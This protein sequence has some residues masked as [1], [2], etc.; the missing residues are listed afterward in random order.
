MK[1]SIRGEKLEVTKAI[2]DYAVEKLSKLDKYL[3][4][5]DKIEAKVH[6][7]HTN[8]IKKV[9]VTIVVN[10]YF[11]RAEEINDDM[12]A[13]IDLISDKIERQFK[14]YKTKLVSKNK[15]NLIFE[16]LEDFFEEEESL[17]DI[18]KT[19]TVFL[20]PMDKLEAITQME[21]LGHTFFVFKDRDSKKV[22]VIYKRKD[23]YYGLIE[24]E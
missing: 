17:E 3:D 5:P 1:Y 22:G 9:E 7:S 2:K 10:N 4:D 24:T 14:K 16:E 8:K 12:Y 21:L 18:V 23:G 19:K 11:L 6:L 13:A 15:I 20:K